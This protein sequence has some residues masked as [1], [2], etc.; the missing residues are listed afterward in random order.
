M[1]KEQP[2]HGYEVMK[3]LEERSDGVYSPSAGT[4]YPSL[5]DLLERGMISIDE[6]A[7]KK[8][9]ELTTDGFA[10]LGEKITEEDE[11][12]WEEWRFQ[13]LWKQSKEAAKLREEMDKYQLEFQLAVRKVLQEPA[14][15]S[16]LTEIIKSSR[17]HLIRWSE[18]MM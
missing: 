4:I 1:L 18:K 11:D 10:F 5:Q 6:Q 14:L 13:L 12:F 2:R 9:Y 15:A 3:L 16:E 8:V 17:D 7:D